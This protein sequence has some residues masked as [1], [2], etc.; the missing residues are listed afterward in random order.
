MKKIILS[1][2]IFGFAFGS[3]AQSDKKVKAGLAYQFGMNFTKPG[4]NNIIKNGVGVQNAIGLNLLFKGNGSIG[5]ATGLEFD[6]DSYKYQMKNNTFYFYS[7]KEIKYKDA[8]NVNDDFYRLTERKYKNVFLT[9]PTMLSFETNP[10]GD[11]IYYGKF[12]LRTSILLK[13]T[14]N[15]EG[16]DAI[17]G[18]V[19]E[20]DGMKNKWGNDVWGFRSAVGLAGGAQWNFTGNTNLF[21]EIGFY[22]GVTPVHNPS[23]K[24][25]NMSL[26]KIEDVNGTPTDV[27]FRPKSNLSQLCLKVGILF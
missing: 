21:A 8:E 4:T 7:D 1:L 2:A 22:Y 11:F 18:L 27:Y 12:G 15:D 24:E 9:I 26:W 3:L 6:F 10:I 14:S 23:S 13:S 5:F 17:S 25:D 20:N 19:K 16:F